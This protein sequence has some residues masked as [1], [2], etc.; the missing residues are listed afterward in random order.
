MSFKV[1]KILEV[2][3]IRT[4][5]E[6]VALHGKHL[7]ANGAQQLCRRLV[8]IEEMFNYERMR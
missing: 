5:C 6:I 4:I 8:S 7:Q 2:P 1:L 3:Y